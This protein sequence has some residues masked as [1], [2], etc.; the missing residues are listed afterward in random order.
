MKTLRAYVTRSFWATFS[1]TVAV[2]TFI[3]SIG[4]LFRITDLLARGIEPGPILQ[5]FL[6]G[7]PNGMIYAIPVGSLTAALLVFG[8]LSG[9]AEITAMRACGISIA[10]V[11][12]WLLPFSLGASF[13]CLYLNS[14]MIPLQYYMRWRATAEL[15][16]DSFLSLLEVG[17]TVSLSDDLRIFVGSVQDDGTL[18]QV[19]IFDQRDAGRL[20]E[21]KADRG[22]L[23]NDPDT[24]AIL[25][26]LEGVTI[27][28]FQFDSPGA[29]Y[30]D[31]WQ[32]PLGQS[33]RQ[34]Y[35]QRDKHRRFH[36]LYVL[37]RKLEL[38]ADRLGEASWLTQ[39]ARLLQQEAY[40]KAEKLRMEAWRAHTHAQD[41]VTH[42]RSQAAAID[43]SDTATW[44]LTRA[45]Q[46]EAEAAEMLSQA[47]SEALRIEE[48][49]WPMV[50]LLMRQS[51]EAQHGIEEP[52]DRL[53]ERALE[54]RIVLNQRLLL[55]F[56]PILFLFFGI[57]MGI[58]PHRRET[59][60]GIAASL[61]V[62]FGFFIILTL[63]GEF[64]GH[65]QIRPDQ[66]VWIPGILMVWA[67]IIL[68]WRMR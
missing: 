25:L 58:R 46:R 35:I 61:L 66:L 39:R 50:R 22:M 65:P 51:R 18:K 4:G 53:R 26:T 17:R 2:L 56:A 7:L 52:E 8:R 36:D 34:V 38:D 67:D 55:S 12:S 41:E 54:M 43:A 49:A 42:L 10:R 31:R 30:S 40:G 28:P 32:M 15:R 47:E 37:S 3:I 27:D 20:R 62:M 44:L 60:I 19:R 68:L 33:A 45:K 21:I 23:A 5:V 13:L 24:G 59:S 29:A 11:A 57:P 1:A 64:R 9:D 63:F 6:S 48:E 14:E 16:A